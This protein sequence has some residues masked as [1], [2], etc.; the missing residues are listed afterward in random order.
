MQHRHAW[1][2]SLDVNIGKQHVLAHV[3]V[4]VR[5]ACP[6]PCCMSMSM[7]HVH[8][9]AA[10]PCPCCMSMPMVCVCVSMSM[11]PVQVFAACS[12]PCCMS[13][14]TLKIMSMLH[15]HVYTENHVHATCPCCITTFMLHAYAHTACPYPYCCMFMSILLH[16]HA[17]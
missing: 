3:D 9:H 12:C 4:H 11:L 8:V 10:C 16:V 1:I 13:I 17:T 7:L 6:C 5:A 2:C 14:S 15:V